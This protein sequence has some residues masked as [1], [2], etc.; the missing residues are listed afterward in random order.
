MIPAKQV[1]CGKVHAH[2]EWYGR[3]FAFPAVY[4][5]AWQAEDGTCAQILVNPGDR[6]E[7]CTVDGR[8]ITVPARDAVMIEL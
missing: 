3:A 6:A 5:T 4:S 7:T 8:E 2:M 1:T